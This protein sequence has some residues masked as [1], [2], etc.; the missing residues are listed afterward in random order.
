MKDLTPEQWE[1]ML[2]KT[3]RRDMYDQMMATSAALARVLAL[4]ECE[5]SHISKARLR[6]A[7]RGDD[8]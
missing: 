7:L 3:P 5:G 2:D 8:Q 1:R 6:I 4:L